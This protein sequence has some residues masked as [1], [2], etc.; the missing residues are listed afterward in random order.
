LKHRYNVNGYIN[1]AT[2]KLRQFNR[3]NSFAE[4]WWNKPLSLY[5][6]QSSYS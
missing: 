6:P 3:A 5:Q 1:D 2:D 4:W